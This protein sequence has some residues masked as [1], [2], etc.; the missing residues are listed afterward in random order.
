MIGSHLGKVGGKELKDESEGGLGVD[1]VV[2]RHYVCMAQL[3]QQ[4]RLMMIMIMMMMMIWMMMMMM[5][6][7]ITAIYLPP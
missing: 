5:M 3:L 2:Q 1:D 7:M 6:V 4:A